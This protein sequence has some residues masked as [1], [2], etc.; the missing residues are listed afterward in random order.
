M[1]SFWRLSALTIAVLSLCDEVHTAVLLCDASILFCLVIISCVSDNFRYH[2]K[3][4]IRRTEAAALP[5][6]PPLNVAAAAAISQPLCK[7][8]TTPSGCRFGTGCRFSHVGPSVGRGDSVIAT[9]GQ[10]SADVDCLLPVVGSAMQ[11]SKARASTGAASDSNSSA[12]AI[13]AYGDT[14]VAP[15]PCPDRRAS[16]SRV[17]GRDLFLL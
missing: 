9:G 14:D 3:R 11:D 2:S 16:P 12:T 8:Y 4:R 15:P 7:W 6:S 5:T 1:Q 17:R 10:S 13:H